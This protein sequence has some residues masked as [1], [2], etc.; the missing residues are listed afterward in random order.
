[1]RR[2]TTLYGAGGEGKTTL[3]QMLATAR[4]LDGGQWLGMPVRKGRTV[5]HFCEDDLEE[6]WRRQEDIN[7]LYGCTFSDLSAMRWLPALGMDNHLMTFAK[8]K[9]QL[10]ELHAEILESI[11][12]HKGDMLI[13]DTLTDIFGGNEI[14]RGQ[15]RAFIQ[16]ALGSIARLTGAAVMALAH[17][18]LSG[19][20]SGTGTS[21]STGWEGAV[22][23]RLY[24]NSP[25]A[26]QGERVD[27]DVRV[28]TLGKANNA[29]RGE[30]IELRW[31]DGTFITTS[32]PT[33]II[34]S[35]E[36]RTCEQVFLAL[37]ARL[38]SEGRYVSENPRAGNYAARV[39]AT[40]PDREGF[41]QPDF[42]SAMQRLFFAK[43]IRKGQYTDASRR[44][45]DCLEPADGT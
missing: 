29:R 30:T 24:L 21:G 15:A 6:M 35:I 41:K 39:F 11:Q 34:A 3:A 19:I 7:R 10:T 14:E 27:P 32:Q 38:R 40:C 28:L 42:T 45:Q 22:R 18:S 4:C 37:L 9:P 20:A 43:A 44:K 2:V 31:A 33:G 25:K 12:E 8:A 16:T 26:E 23:S 17:P 36:K 5:L 13:N 1:M